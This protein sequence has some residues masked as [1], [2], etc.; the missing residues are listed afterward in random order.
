MGRGSGGLVLCIGGGGE[1]AALLRFVVRQGI[2]S[3]GV[4]V[5]CGDA[6]APGARSPSVRP[7]AA[8]GAR[9]ERRAVAVSIGNI[10]DGDGAFKSRAM[11]ADSRRPSSRCFLRNTPACNLPLPCSC[12]NSHG[13]VSQ[14][15]E[16]GGRSA[17]RG[18][19][20]REAAR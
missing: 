3:I 13:I 7:P 4:I 9:T 15:P 20:A 10:V 2:N 19:V 6:V 1:L 8:I 18:A 11:T 12:S 16:N 5:V 17:A 14:G